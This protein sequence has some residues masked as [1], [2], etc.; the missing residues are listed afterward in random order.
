[1]GELNYYCENHFQASRQAC[2][3]NGYTVSEVLPQPEGDG[4]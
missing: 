3:D 4:F 1:M 2:E